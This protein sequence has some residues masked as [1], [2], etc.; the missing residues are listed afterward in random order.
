MT[1]WIISPDSLELSSEHRPKG[2]KCCSF[3][4]KWNEIVKDMGSESSER[5]VYTVGAITTPN[6]KRSSFG[7]FQVHDEGDLIYRTALF[8]PFRTT[9]TY[10]VKKKNLTSNIVHSLLPI[11]VGGLWPSGRHLADIM[12]M[13]LL[14]DSGLLFIHGGAFRLDGKT[15]GLFS[16]GQTG[17]T[18]TIESLVQNGAKYLGEDALLTD[19]KTVHLVPPFAHDMFSFL[20]KENVLRASTMDRIYICERGKVNGTSERTRAIS[21]LRMF[22]NRVPFNNDGLVQALISYHGLD[23]RNL[24]N[25]CVEIVEKLVDGTEVR[26]IRSINEMVAELDGR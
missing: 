17:K 11:E 10:D 13:D 15:I 7:P 1:R 5:Y 21:H 18:T 22:S 4:E 8:G 16:P 3:N 23:F 26:F 12:A 19:G 24:E 25:E 9:F 20:N 6:G 14:K 2:F